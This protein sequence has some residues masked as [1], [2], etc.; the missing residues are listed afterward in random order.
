MD[1]QD[2]E[3]LNIR[4]AAELLKVSETS[5]RRWTNAGLLTCL[6]VGPKRERRF[7]R[8]DL[9]AFLRQ[10]AGSE[11]STHGVPEAHAP[12]TLAPGV[13]LEHGTHFCSLY[14]SDSG[15]TA[16]AVGFLAD[17]L[18]EGSACY[19]VATPK[20]AQTCLAQ[21]RRSHP[22]VD[23]DL[24][25]GRLSVME[26]ASD[27]KRQIESLAARFR[28]ALRAGAKSIRLVGNM[29]EGQLVRG[30][31]FASALRYEED[32]DTQLA[33]RFPLVTL[34]Q[35]DARRHS[36]VDLLEVYKRHGGVFRY[37][38]DRLLS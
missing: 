32:Y 6:R 21:L 24:A 34:C 3:L 7:R 19:L 18:R 17:G 37:P 5:L 38:S 12:Q 20:A 28:A 8:S 26:Y 16:L 22:G 9:V 35:Y 4:E 33:R 36:G 1:T 25:V 30:K 31:A 14:G 13:R 10:A 11:R 29:S 15:R 23:E 2:I 27:A